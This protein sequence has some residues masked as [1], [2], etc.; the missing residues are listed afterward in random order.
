MLVL[1][2]RER[3][4][5]AN[6]YAESMTGW[7]RDELIGQRWSVLQPG[8]S[9]AWISQ[10]M[11]RLIRHVRLEIVDRTG[12]SLRVVA[13]LAPIGAERLLFTVRQFWPNDLRTRTNSGEFEYTIAAAPGSFTLLRSHN[14][15]EATDA[16]SARLCFRRLF[17]RS[18]PCT[19]CPILYSG[20]KSWPR[21]AVRASRRS[22]GGFEVV[23]AH[24][25]VNDEV[26]VTVRQ[27]SAEAWKSTL[28]TKIAQMSNRARL[29]PRERSVLGH[30]IEG[31]TISEMADLLGVQPST[32]KFHQANVLRK[33]GID[34]R[35]NI[36]RA[37]F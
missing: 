10:A 35:T 13:D 33:L 32:V 37:L 7:P 25:P 26:E 34:S 19:D 4:V 21:I 11:Q 28:S 24:E 23:T 31:R 15:P 22:P 1:D 27:L 16:P 18:E 30:L 3:V 36:V 6:V 14:A 29:S 2:R 17:G 5:L 8:E 9:A 12:A 20:S